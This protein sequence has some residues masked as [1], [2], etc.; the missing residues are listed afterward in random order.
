M[1][2]VNKLK[3]SKLC[4]ATTVAVQIVAKPYLWQLLSQVSLKSNHS[5][6]F[7]NNLDLTRLF[8]EAIFTAIFRPVMRVLLSFNLSWR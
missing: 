2:Y 3:I 1:N 5:L 7:S 8:T 4:A 6:N